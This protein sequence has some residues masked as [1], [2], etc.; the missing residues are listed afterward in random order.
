VEAYKQSGV[1][2]KKEWIA[3]MDSRVR[4]S[5]AAADGQVV[6]IDKPFEVGGVLMNAPSQINC[7]CAVSPVIVD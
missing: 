2:P 5:H 4:P 3:T 6:D 7:R 1:V